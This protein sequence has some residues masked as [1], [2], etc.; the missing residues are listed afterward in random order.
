MTGM[1]GQAL[2]AQS[3]TQAFDANTIKAIESQFIQSMVSMKVEIDKATASWKEFEMEMGTVDALTGIEQLDAKLA[4]VAESATDAKTKIT[5]LTVDG[6][7]KEGAE[8][9][10]A[11]AAKGGQKQSL[12]DRIGSA[13]TESTGVSAAIEASR[14]KTANKAMAANRG[15]SMLGT[16]Q[17]LQVAPKLD[18][19]A[20][21]AVE[22][23]FKDKMKAMGKTVE[24]IDAAWSA[25]EN[26]LGDGNA[27]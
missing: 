21:A 7:G 10:G 4:K 1:K 12:K 24:E 15:K 8:T 22:K 14:A 18:G 20:L 26:N 13:L 11:A 23:Q 25:L 3:F 2:G 17:T 27:V 9:I 19:K 5:Q 16:M 6:A